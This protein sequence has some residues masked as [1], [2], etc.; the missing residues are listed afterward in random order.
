MNYLK[1]HILLQVIM[2]RHSVKENICITVYLFGRIK[3]MFFMKE[4]K[5]KNNNNS[6]NNNNNNKN[7]KAN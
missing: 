7:I 4:K 5:G 6:N 2:M 3:I 1:L